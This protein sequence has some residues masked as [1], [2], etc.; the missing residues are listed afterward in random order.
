MSVLS[1][2]NNL[3][4][5]DYSNIHIKATIEPMGITYPAFT[6]LI[7]A[8]KIDRNTEKL[9][10]IYCNTIYIGSMILD[11][12]G[13]LE[14]YFSPGIN[15]IPHFLRGKIITF[16]IADPS[17]DPFMLVEIFK[18]VVNPSSGAKDSGLLSSLPNK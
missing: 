10:V 3:F 11:E 17:F 2:I 13:R 4:G 15:G 7:G 12:S 14:V 5:S 8:H 18:S 16:D 6:G 1:E 9:D